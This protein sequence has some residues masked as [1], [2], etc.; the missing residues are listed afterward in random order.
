MTTN[1]AIILAGG[2]GSRLGGDIPKQLLKIAGK[3]VIEHTL[4]VFESHMEIHEIAIVSNPDYIRDVEKILMDRDFKKV[5]KILAGGAERY[6]SSLVAI[7]AYEDED[8]NLIFHDAVRPLVST[9]IISDCIHALNTYNAVDVAVKTTDTIISVKEDLIEHIPNRAHLYN[10]Q[11]PQAFTWNTIHAAYEKALQDPDFRATDDCGVVKKYLPEEPVYVVQGEGYN[12][13][14]T[15]PEDIF[16]L[17]KLFRLKSVSDISQQLTAKSQANL[18]HKVVV[19]F[20]G[21]YGIGKDVGALCTQQGARVYAFSRSSTNT[22]IA[23]VKAIKK[24]LADVYRKENRID[25]VVNTAGILEI[26]ALQN[27]SYEDIQ[28]NIQVNYFGSIAVAKESYPYLQKS[29]GGLLLYTSSSY[30]RGRGLYSLYSTAK[31]A[32]VNLTQALSQE[33]EDDLI[34]CINPERT[35]TPMRVRNF[36]QEP[37]DSLLSSE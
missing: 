28:K 20:G 6:D 2:K 36:G 3:K 15:Y 19:I 29:K 18:K 34:N 14:L 21:S 7:R 10:G 22:N 4:E 33:W 17:D 23:D 32:L 11:T 8:V 26:Q 35:K 24:A 37:K 12:M 27:M 5:K 30:T 9:R 25:F 31:A 13:K 16:L 1:I